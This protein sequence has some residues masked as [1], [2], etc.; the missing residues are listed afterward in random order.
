MALLLLGLLGLQVLPCY[1]IV[2]GSC[3]LGSSIFTSQAQLDSIKADCSLING[4]V[5]IQCTPQNEIT[6]LKAL[7][8]IERITGYLRIVGCSRLSDFAPLRNLK[9]IDGNSLHTEAGVGSGFAV[10]IADNS[11][12]KTLNGLQNLTSVGKNSPAP[13]HGRVYISQNPQ[14][15]WSRH[16]NWRMVFGPKWTRFV[17]EN[18][19]TSCVGVAQCHSSCTCG[20]CVGPG[21]NDCIGTCEDFSDAETL[22]VV[23]LILIIIIVGTVGVFL[24]LYVTDRCGCRIQH[25][26][27]TWF[28]GHFPSEDNTAA[29]RRTSIQGEA[30]TETLLALKHMDANNSATASTSFAVPKVS[31]GS[32]MRE[33][34]TNKSGATKNP[35]NM[36]D[37]TMSQNQN[38]PSSHTNDDND[39]NDKDSASSQASGSGSDSE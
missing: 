21:S 29:R 4:N 23:T 37:S 39:D 35:N 16:L 24:F 26:S 13:L 6:S 3:D 27:K 14:L 8:L 9:A 31:E 20:Y 7:R 25:Y 38:K 2:G 17:Y 33:R 15:C 10:Y 30:W 34:K 32:T 18:I 1:G 36:N 28:I 5:N 12:L 19:G 11:A 22:I